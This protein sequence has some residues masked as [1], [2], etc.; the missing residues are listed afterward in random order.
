M[1]QKDNSLTVIDALIESKRGLEHTFVPGRKESKV[2][3]DRSITVWIHR[4]KYF[5]RHDSAQIEPANGRKGLA[6][7]TRSCRISPH[8]I[9]PP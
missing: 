5:H 4:L 1:E 3:L 9:D 2:R 8:R 7:T 6:L